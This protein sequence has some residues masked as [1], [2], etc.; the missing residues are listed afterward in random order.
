MGAVLPARSNDH[1]KDLAKRTL[2]AMPKPLT[3]TVAGP[4]GQIPRYWKLI[5][6]PDNHPG[7]A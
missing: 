1:E 2:R 7:G 5:A 6:E 4:A 3:C